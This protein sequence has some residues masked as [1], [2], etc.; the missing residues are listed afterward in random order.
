M[1]KRSN[2]V[3]DDGRSLSKNERLHV[4]FLVLITINIFL[5]SRFPEFWYHFVSFICFLGAAIAVFSII[6]ES[7][8]PAAKNWNIF[9]FAVYVFCCFSAIVFMLV[10]IKAM[11]AILNFLATFQ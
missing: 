3:F 2:S 9:L 7:H 11:E 1:A 10:D 5:G 6:K 8:F 4:I